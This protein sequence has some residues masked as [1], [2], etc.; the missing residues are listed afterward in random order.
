MQSMN[1]TLDQRNSSQLLIDDRESRVLVVD[2]NPMDVELARATLQQS[3]IVE[4][5][6]DGESGYNL[7]LECKPSCIVSDV[8]M[9]MMSGFTMLKKIR[10][11]TELSEIPVLLLTALDEPL[12]KVHGYELLADIYLTKPVN[13]DELLAAVKSLVR[14]NQKRKVNPDPVETPGEGISE[15]DQRFLEKILKAIHDN[16]KNPDYNVLALSLDVHASKRQVE[17][18][19]KKL[20]NISPADYIRQ[21]RLEQAKRLLQSGS[22]NSIADLAYRVGFRDAKHFSKLFKSF[23]GYQ[24]SVKSK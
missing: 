9:P 1:T 15:D 3:F 20:E 19:L 22:P 7:A 10:A 2:D 6:L 21:V 23:Y 13:T 5:A 18:R 14:M 24:P 16:I 12:N 11:H 8:R 17:R 4:T